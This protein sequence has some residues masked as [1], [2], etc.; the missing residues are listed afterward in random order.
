MFKFIKNG[1][2]F[3][4]LAKSFGGLYLKIQELERNLNNNNI[5]DEDLEIEIETLSYIARVEIWD[6]IEYNNWGLEGK[7]FVPHM[8]KGRITIMYA[9]DQTVQ[10][11]MQLATQTG[12]EDI[13]FDMMQ[14]GKIFKEYQKFVAS[15]L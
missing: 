7:I 14:K 10:K 1:V 8:Q 6:R 12:Y 13:Y 15:H 9:I 11:I 5:E 2:E 3:N 4:K